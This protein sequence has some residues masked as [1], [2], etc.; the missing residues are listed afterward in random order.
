MS[1]TS[2]SH[3]HHRRVQH[4]E[5][6]DKDLYLSK[7]AVQELMQDINVRNNTRSKYTFQ[8]IS[9]KC[10][11]TILSHADNVTPDRGWYGRIR[12]GSLQVYDLLIL[13]MTST[14]D[15][16]LRIWR[17]RIGAELRKDLRNWSD[18]IYSWADLGRNFDSVSKH[19]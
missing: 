6:F 10:E 12:N 3:F 4:L 1:T 2:L 5:T 8:S 15:A 14:K 16:K 17:F 13:I 7:R 11:A 19:E 18:L 9:E